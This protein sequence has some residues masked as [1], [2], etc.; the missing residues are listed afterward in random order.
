MIKNNRKDVGAWAPSCVQHGFT[1]CPTF[2]DD[3][4]RVPS[5]SGKMVY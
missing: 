4:F 2:T 1:D 3:R 5:N